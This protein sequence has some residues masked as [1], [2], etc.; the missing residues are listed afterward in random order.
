MWN[1]AKDHSSCWKRSSMNEQLWLISNKYSA[2]LR[3]IFSLFMD[4]FKIATSFI[5][6]FAML[7]IVCDQKRI[8]GE[9]PKPKILNLK[10]WNFTETVITA[11]RYIFSQKWH[12]WL[13]INVLV[14]NWLFWPKMSLL[15]LIPLIKYRVHGTLL[16]QPDELSM[17]EKL[18]FGRN[19]Q[20]SAKMVIFGRKYSFDW[21]AE[22]SQ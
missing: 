7:V 17:M 8:F 6:K 13:K 10:R 22:N 19:C 18:N 2:D 12:F 5:Y 9:T 20:F 11:V 21:M 3:G 4:M 15:V 1:F 16:N 14:E